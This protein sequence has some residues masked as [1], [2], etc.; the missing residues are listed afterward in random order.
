M[1]SGPVQ[2]Q[3]DSDTDSEDSEGGFE[4]RAVA[5]RGGPAPKKARDDAAPLN[6][7]PDWDASVNAADKV[8]SRTSYERFNVKLLNGSIVSVKPI[9]VPFP[10]VGNDGHGYFVKDISGAPNLPTDRIRTT[11]ATET[12][13]ESLRLLKDRLIE[14]KFTDNAWIGTKIGIVGYADK[15]RVNMSL[16]HPLNP[17]D[18][19]I[20]TAWN[21][22]ESIGKRLQIPTPLRTFG[23]STVAP[24][25]GA[26]LFHR[27][28]PWDSNY[29]TV[30]VG[31]TESPDAG[32][33]LLMPPTHKRFYDV[34]RMTF[35]LG[36]IG[37]D[38]PPDMAKHYNVP[39]ASLATCDFC[40]NIF[41][42]PHLRL[43]HQPFCHSNPTVYAIPPVEATI[44]ILIAD[45]TL[46]QRTAWEAH[47]NSRSYPNE[48]FAPLNKPTDQIGLAMAR[49][50]K[51][52][53]VKLLLARQGW[54][55]AELSDEQ[56]KY[57]RPHIECP[58]AMEYS[59][60]CPEFS[61]GR[62]YETHSTFKDVEVVQT[63][64]DS[65]RVMVRHRQQPG[66][67]LAWDGRVCHAGS[68]N[69][70]T[71]LREVIFLTF[72]DAVD[73]AQHPAAIKPL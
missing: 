28:A 72:H 10:M 24:N 70:G 47:K 7:P 29:W 2:V 41:P 21:V 30:V 8:W 16:S 50:D 15:Q 66:D 44:P 23:Y 61:L 26:Q 67:V 39:V 11:I 55:D 33:R 69:A 38:R 25:A 65:E 1:P 5:T 34:S 32:T 59:D 6:T 49:G 64:I 45:P 43:Q 17:H 51:P 40:R 48:V 60:S 35:P 53:R 68:R 19:L 27:D 13:I 36:V 22:A 71:T 73:P 54:V 46:E 62:G 57:N 18:E 52:V 12:E 20:Q 58:V 9:Y 37:D 4:D 14:S 3:V 31:L 56:H 63:E 42:G